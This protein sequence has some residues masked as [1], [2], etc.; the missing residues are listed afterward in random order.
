MNDCISLEALKHITKLNALRY[1]SRREWAME[2]GLDYHRLNHFMS[3]R[4]GPPPQLLH[5]LGFEKIT[6]YRRKP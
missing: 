4:I 6:V 3:G 5:L 2:N 1:R